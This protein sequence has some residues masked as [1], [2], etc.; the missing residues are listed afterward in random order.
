MESISFNKFRDNL[1]SS[2]DSVAARHEPLKVTQQ[3]GI[4]FIIMSAKDWERER[5]TL[6]ILQDPYLMSQI[7]ASQQTR[8][9]QG[10]YIPTQQEL[11]EILSVDEE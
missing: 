3:N 2:V 11:D 1:E 7:R 6:Y 4:D 9:K 8:G 5:E 10:G